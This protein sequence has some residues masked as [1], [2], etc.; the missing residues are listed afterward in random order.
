MSN[1]SKL[2]A[3]LA[4]SLLALFAIDSLLLFLWRQTAPNSF[5][6]D[7]ILCI[8]I[9]T[10]CGFPLFLVIRKNMGTKA[11]RSP[12]KGFWLQL[13][14]EP[15]LVVLFLISFVS[16][17]V[18]VQT[19]TLL[20]IDRS[21]SYFILEWIECSPSN[22]LFLVENKV[23]SIFGSGEIRAFN[24]RLVEQEARGVIAREGGNVNLTR[25]G[26]FLFR[27]SEMSAGVFNLSGWETNKVWKDS[28]C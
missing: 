28:K 3:K 15:T 9:V 23:A 7:Q 19:Q 18:L 2:G 5:L 4:S 12:V 13:I 26:S 1:E 14:D 22:E 6:A 16:S 25:F 21:R 27:F 20:N 8:A 11:G 10:A 24:L 17:T